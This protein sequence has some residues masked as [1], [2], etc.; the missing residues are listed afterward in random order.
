MEM[1]TFDGDINPV[2]LPIL[3]LDWNIRDKCGNRRRVLFNKWNDG[4]N[5]NF[6][7]ELTQAEVQAT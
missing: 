3:I 7:L 4:R 1:M 2:Q 6:Y 5:R